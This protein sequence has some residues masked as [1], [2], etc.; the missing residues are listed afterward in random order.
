MY[1]VF[2]LVEF[3]YPITGDVMNNDIHVTINAKYNN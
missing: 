1:V 3:V 2:L